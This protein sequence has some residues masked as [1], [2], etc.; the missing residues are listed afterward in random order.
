LEGGKR[1]SVDNEVEEGS[2]ADL[3]VELAQGREGVGVSVTDRD[4]RFNPVVEAFPDSMKDGKIELRLIQQVWAVIPERSIQLI[5][6]ILDVDSVLEK[7]VSL[8]SQVPQQLFVCESV[9]IVAK[10]KRFKEES[11]ENFKG[12]SRRW[13]H[14]VHDVEMR[15]VLAGG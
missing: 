11:E 5:R 8:D 4:E 6:V 3:E 7:H 2:A 15:E 12:A 1:G 10:G 14:T 9:R 13:R